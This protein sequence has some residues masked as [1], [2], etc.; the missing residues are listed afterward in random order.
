MK[1]RC[2]ALSISIAIALFE[3]GTQQ[4]RVLL[5][6]SAGKLT[7]LRVAIDKLDIALDEYAKRFLERTVGISVSRLTQSIT[8]E[9]LHLDP[10]A[11]DISYYG[12]TRSQFV[13]GDDLVWIP[14]YHLLPDQD[15]RQP[16][17][18]N[19]MDTVHEDIQMSGHDRHLLTA[20]LNTL[21]R[22]LDRRPV[23]E[24]IEP[25]AFTLSYL[26]QRTEMLLGSSLHTQNF[27]RRILESGFLEPIDIAVVQS[28]GRP[29]LLY[30]VRSRIRD[31][32]IE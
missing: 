26:Q 31:A 14:L 1:D 7:L 3:L 30:Q 9:D 25:A 10:P 2:Q 28:L 15:R 12:F 17:M 18:T 21:R 32:T 16:A 6:R 24:E 5:H 23:I 29:A 22:S 13:N 27:R 8:D 11:I 20:S 4:P 19:S